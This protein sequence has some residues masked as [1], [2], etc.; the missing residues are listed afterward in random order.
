MKM[1][2]TKLREIERGKKQNE[3]KTEAPNRKPK[4][5]IT[6]ITEGNQQTSSALRNT[7]WLNQENEP[8]SSQRDL[9]NPG[10]KLIRTRDLDYRSL[11]G[12]R[13]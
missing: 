9:Y 10:I 12:T 11:L 6:D 1:K 5:R 13:I 2:E 7:A 8:D 4:Q 3:P